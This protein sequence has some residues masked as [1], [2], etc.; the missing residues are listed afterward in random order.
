[1]YIWYLPHVTT[2]CACYYITTLWCIDNRYVYYS[3]QLFV[4]YTV[5]RRAAIMVLLPMR[6]RGKEAHMD[7]LFFI[8]H[9]DIIIISISRTQLK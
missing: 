8:T 7:A 3:I 4:V 2:V 9:H 6:W 5:D 1:M